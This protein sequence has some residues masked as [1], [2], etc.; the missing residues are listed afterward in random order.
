M[1]I[2]NEKRLRGIRGGKGEWHRPV[3]DKADYDKR[4]AGIDWGKKA[5]KK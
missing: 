1:P 4:F 2:T 3:A 5:V